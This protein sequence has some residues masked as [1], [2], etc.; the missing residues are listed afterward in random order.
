MTVY[1]RPDPIPRPSSRP[2]VV[3]DWA[4][5]TRNAVGPT[6]GGS[7]LT[8]NLFLF[9]LRDGLTE[10]AGFPVEADLCKQ[11]EVSR[12]ALREAIKRLEAKGVL[13]VKRRSGTVVAARSNWAL[14][15]P[16]LLRWQV[17]AGHREVSADLWGALGHLMPN[18][19]KADTVDSQLKALEV[20]VRLMRNPLLASIAGRIVA[21][22]HAEGRPWLEMQLASRQDIDRSSEPPHLGKATV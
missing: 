17:E 10:G 22:F 8:R 5:S 6:E 21:H 14:L 11:F 13:V 2:Q 18:L 15:D 7:N 9:V 19:A 1:R 3:E 4:V 16:D 20:E 12:T